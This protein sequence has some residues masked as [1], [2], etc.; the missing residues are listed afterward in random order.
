[1]TA[2]ETLDYPSL[3][4]RSLELVKQGK[5]TSLIQVAKALGVNYNTLAAGFTRHFDISN[6]DDLLRKRDVIEKKIDGF[7]GDK[8]EVEFDGNFGE[9]RAVDVRGQIRTVDQLLDAAGIDREEWEPYQPE[10]RKWDVILKL[11][12]GDYD[13][14]RVVPSFYVGAKIRAIMPRAFEPVVQPVEISGVTY[15]GKGKKAKAKK[16]VI[17]RAL[18]LNDPQIGFRRRMHMSELSPF[19][20]RRVIDLALQVA[21]SEQI[22]HISFGG[23]WGDYSEWSSKYLPEPEFFWTTQPALIEQAYWFARFRAAQPDAEMKLLEGNH[24]ARLMNL[25]VANMR[26]AYRLKAVDELS[27]PPSLSVPRLLALHQLGIEYVGGYPDTGYWLN[28]NVFV[29]HGDVVRSA[30][31]ATA[32]EVAKRQAFTT[33]FGHIHRREL[34]AR[35]MK[36]SDGDLIYSAFCPG[37]ACHIDGRVPGSSSSQQWQ[38]GF[39]VVEY[40]EDS[41]NIIPI[42]VQDGRMMYNGKVWS[43]RDVDGELDQVI[44]GGLEQVTA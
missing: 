30:P 25:I 36:T 15:A 4:Q 26:Q 22:D 18:I 11:R 42:A 8:I 41:E 39:A 32:G 43:A 37:C 3:L 40:T 10:V 21:E 34:V 2:K 33:I 14:V 12:D 38:Q 31:G 7:E 24:D 35:R 29:T 1:M 6:F 27:L 16:D 28:K 20:D 9:V 19:H 44:M 23:D 13:L 5:V 17:R